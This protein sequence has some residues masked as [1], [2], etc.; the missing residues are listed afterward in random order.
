M[1]GVPS[2]HPPRYKQQ[3]NWVTCPGP[4]QVGLDA[5]GRVPVNLQH[6]TLPP[7]A[8][9][10]CCCGA[11]DPA[12]SVGG[13]GRAR[14]LGRHVEYLGGSNPRQVTLLISFPLTYSPTPRSSYLPVHPQM[15]K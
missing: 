3:N 15:P 14:L 12:H 9:R 2:A 1:L 13:D 6:G 10:R 5:L 11:A 7:P 8:A 4:E